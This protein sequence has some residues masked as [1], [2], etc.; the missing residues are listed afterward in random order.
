MRAN[1]RDDH[2]STHVLEAVIMASIMV[3]AVA[4]VV[5]FDSPPLT[6][7]PTRDSLKQRAQDAI[8][9]LYDT[10]VTGSSF[11]ENALSVYLAECMSGDCANLT[12]KLSRVLPEGAG[13]AVYVSNGYLTF[14]VYAPR[15]PAGEAVTATHLLEP[16]WSYSFLATGMS[17]VNPTTDALVTYSLPIF[18]SNVVSQGGSPLRVAVHGT[19]T[20]DG[21]NYTATGFF[22]TQ[23]MASADAGQ[24][25]AAS[26]YF[27]NNGVPVARW[28]ASGVTASVGQPKNL[29]FQ[30]RLDET[31]GVAIPAGTE[32]TVSL[33]RGWTGGALPSANPGWLVLGNA[34]SASSSYQGSDITARLLSDVTGTTKDF[35]FYAHYHGDA[36]EWYPF[37]ARLSKGALSEAN[38]LVRPNATAADASFA[39]PQVAMSVPRPMGA[40]ATTTWT[41]TVDIPA[42]VDERVSLPQSKVTTKSSAIRLDGFG[43][44][45]PALEETE[46]E[47][48]VI[49]IDRI[50]IL[51]QDGA[52][53]FG[54]VQALSGSGAWKAEGDRLVW[55][56]SHLNSR[57][58][59]GLAFKVTGSGV[60][61][62]A[63]SKNPF[64]PPVQFEDHKGRL[65][66]QVA[67][68]FYRGVHL[69]GGLGSNWDGYGNTYGENGDLK[70]GRTLRSDAVYRSTLLPGKA[71]YSINPVTSFQDSIH[72]SYVAV[73][74]RNVPIGG[75]AVLSADVQSLLFA[76]SQAGISAGVNLH[77]YPP[78]SG[79]ARDP[80]YTQ[81]NLDSGILGSDV[82]QLHLMEMNGDAYPDVVVGTSNGRVLA[83]DGLTGARLQGN[84]F[85]AALRAGALE[86]AVTGITHLV[87][88]HHKGKDYLV[89]GTDK[90]GAGIYVLDSKL[91]LKWSWEKGSRETLAVDASVDITGDGANDVLV[92]LDDSGVYVLVPPANADD[93][94]QTKLKP[95]Q[96]P[97]TESVLADAFY[98][99]L[100]KPT[101][102]VGMKGIG[103]D[104][105]LSGFAVTFQSMPGLAPINLLDPTTID[106]ILDLPRAGFQGVDRTGKPTWTFFGS[107]VTSAQGYDYDGD[108][109]TDVV[110]GS[111]AGFVYMMNGKVATQPLYSLIFPGAGVR[112]ADG[113]TPFEQAYLGTDG[114]IRFTANGWITSTCAFCRNS[115]IPTAL[116]PEAMGVAM[117]GS[118]SFWAVGA[119]NLLLRSIPGLGPS[120]Q[121]EPQ[122]P[123]MA[124]V[125]AN[126]TKTGVDGGYFTGRTHVFNDVYFKAAPD[127]DKGFVIGGRCIQAGCEESLVMRTLD[128][129]HSWRVHTLGDTLGSLR[130]YENGV[131]RG[132]LLRINF[133]TDQVGWITGRAGTLLRTTD[134]GTSWHGV[135]TPAGLEDV[136]DFTCDPADPSHCMLLTQTKG[137]VTKQALS[138]DRLN[139]PWTRLEL[140]L[141]STTDEAKAAEQTAKPK[142]LYTRALKSVSMQSGKVAFIG[143]EN[144]ILKTLDGGASWTTLPMN[145][146]EGD[147]A[148]IV[149]FPD[150]R[151]MLYGGN[152]SHARVFFMHD[153]DI[154]S[155]A[156]TTSLLK[157]QGT[158]RIA[159]ITLDTEYIPYKT[160][161]IA[162]FLASA[163]GG[164]N[165]E[166]LDTYETATVSVRKQ[167]SLSSAVETHHY[168]AFL[169]NDNKG[170]D[171]R[172]R[173]QF[174]TEGDETLITAQVRS[175]VAKVLIEDTAV[176][177]SLREAQIVVD[178]KDP[179]RVDEE[180]TTAA[181]DLSQGVIHQ[182][183]VKEYWTRN[184][185]GEVRA[186]QTGLDVSGDG[187]NE[188][189]IGT[190]G[191]L[192]ANS[193]EHAI[194]AGTDLD[195]WIRNDNRVY[196]LDGSN[197]T[198]LNRTAP[199]AGNVTHLALSD[200]NGDGKPEQLFVA[201]WDPGRSNGTLEALDPLSLQ[202]LWTTWLD[203]H[204]PADL[205]AGLSE[206]PYGSA[207]VGTQASQTGQ[208]AISGKVY[209]LRG[210]DANVNWAAIPDQLGRYIITKDIPTSWLFGPYVVEVEVKW[211]NDLESDTDGDDE[212]PGQG[213]LQTAR[214]Y[215]YFVVT[216]PDALAPPSPVYQVHLVTWF[217]DWR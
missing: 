19:R 169:I 25:P 155:A 194:Y 172:L 80:I 36:L 137:W 177:G 67:P 163:D 203:F 178:L 189:W 207:V 160:A 103:P 115:P 204:Q 34:T 96:G 58:P 90:E 145:Y 144:M 193:P 78:W 209:S 143:A 128:G 171:L 54:A 118:H 188:V 120:G 13:Y 47:A 202:P 100:G 51:E 109:A 45:R 56:G 135:K 210:D 81:P 20:S 200:D 53:I 62:A 151:G 12:D 85:T 101:A 6:S 11:G 141:V 175:L 116:F 131:V 176:P 46:Q 97:N 39:V 140:D 93:P 40:G 173:M 206:G 91:N 14:E 142:T 198:I 199:Y 186:I 164:E 22:S 15:E 159:N 182:A 114:Q 168:R 196:L 84:A 104:P 146:L 157:L 179:A 68:G 192:A 82:T 50:E 69:P 197:G 106:V 132:E 59:L 70:S 87:P 126:A 215:D 30:L 190:G 149:A 180:N 43:Q 183:P 74:K 124:I 21:A 66:T 148:R 18:N 41:L 10:P 112:D 27:V 49:V 65:L 71:N 83:L 73:E 8:D 158:E 138:D 111:P 23:A 156:Q 165:W 75:T 161:A 121:E 129:G 24:H 29:T 108:A 181:W 99:T 110:A 119:G 133:T 63:G 122:H 26:L 1:L 123:Y 37:E 130:S 150:G 205:K 154:A 187:R 162:E 64:V 9:G 166:R 136:V 113:H 7:S 94:A 72:G 5:T 185:S 213:V 55:T 89:V 4:Y 174:L 32:V 170:Q 77:F 61:G 125:P 191:V 2:G 152:A 147:A 52:K 79:D 16:A 184:V 201:T 92:G 60:A 211:T 95:Y 102:L 35:L 208:N 117:N 57:G 134:G 3:S 107:P 153:Y 33:P 76:L 42:Q 44:P 31:G 127:N 28:D 217:D 212:L 214:F 195:K 88:Y 216:P 86:G 17:Q 48:G 38:I 167:G 105:A 98:V 139:V